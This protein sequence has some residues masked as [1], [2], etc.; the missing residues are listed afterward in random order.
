MI[1][2]GLC[3]ECHQPVGS[4]HGTDPYKHA[5][6]CLHVSPGRAADILDAASKKNEEYGRRV[7][8]LLAMADKEE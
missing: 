8:A 5:I 7:A 6:A 1:K 2:S 3:P 4:R